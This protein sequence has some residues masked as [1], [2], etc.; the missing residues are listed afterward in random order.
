MPRL[1]ESA[2]ILER[3]VVNGVGQPDRV[4]QLAYVIRPHTMV[5]TNGSAFQLAR[6][7]WDYFPRDERLVKRRSLSKSEHIFINFAAYYSAVSKADTRRYN[8]LSLQ[9]RLL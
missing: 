5:L 8:P 4:L 6:G 3:I 9:P 1:L 2:P 7:G